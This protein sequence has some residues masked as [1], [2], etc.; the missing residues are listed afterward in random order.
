MS[1]FDSHIAQIC[2]THRCL[3]LDVSEFLYICW[4]YQWWMFFWITVLNVHGIYNYCEKWWIRSDMLIH[5]RQG[6]CSHLYIMPVIVTRFHNH[7]SIRVFTWLYFKD[8][9]SAIVYPSCSFWDLLSPNRTRIRH[10]DISISGTEIYQT[11]IEI[12]LLK[13]CNCHTV[14]ISSAMRCIV[15]ILEI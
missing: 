10:L 7:H 9:E 15:I 12:L 3:H 5:P 8:N 11:M 1:S 6:L 14:K 2:V 4:K 13:I